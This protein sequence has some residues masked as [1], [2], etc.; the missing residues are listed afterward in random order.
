MAIIHKHTIGNIEYQWIDSLYPTHTASMGTICNNI[1]G[2]LFINRSG[3]EIWRALVPSVG[4]SILG[5]ISDNDVSSNLNEWNNPGTGTTGS[6]NTHMSSPSASQLHSTY[7]LVPATHDGIWDVNYTQ[8]FESGEGLN[9]QPIIDIRRKNSGAELPAAD[10]AYGDDFGSNF[11]SR[12][13]SE[14]FYGN[15]NAESSTTLHLNILYEATLNLS[16]SFE[17]AWALT[18]TGGTPPDIVTIQ[19]WNCWATLLEPLYRGFF[20][21][22]V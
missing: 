13:I 7:N 18:N 1:K 16:Q 11:A 10:D 12:S 21:N 6:W 15:V 8:Q 4:S 20:E 19:H 22:W 3:T 9:G 5:G 17:P 14:G 2:Q